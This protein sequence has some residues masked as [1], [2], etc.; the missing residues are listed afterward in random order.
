MVL[1][2]QR[3]HL[4]DFKALVN[5]GDLDNQVFKSVKYGSSLNCP[6]PLK[7]PLVKSDIE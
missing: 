6:T 5:P 7:K 4:I 3:D 1:K 2:L